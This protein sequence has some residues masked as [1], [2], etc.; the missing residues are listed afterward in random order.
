MSNSIEVK[1]PD[2][3]EFKDVEVIEVLVAPGDRIEPR[4][5]ALAWPLRVRMSPRARLPRRWA[6]R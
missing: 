6:P 5:R 4:E 2:I 3:G 1:V